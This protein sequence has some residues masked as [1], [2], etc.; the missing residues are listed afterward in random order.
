MKKN[1]KII[2]I[3]AVV[4]VL[5]YA[6]YLAYQFS[7]N[8]FGSSSEAKT[9]STTSVSLSD[10]IAKGYDESEARLILA[11]LEAGIQVSY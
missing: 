2:I 5:I 4:A 11:K 1:T 10:I 3:V 8:P 9:D 6:A 7:S